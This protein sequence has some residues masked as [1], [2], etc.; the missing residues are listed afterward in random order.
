MKKKELLRLFSFLLALGIACSSVHVLPAQVYATETSSDDE[1]SEKEKE[2][3]AKEQAKKEMQEAVD[4]DKEK[5]DAAKLENSESRDALSNMAKEKANL[6]TAKD[7]LSEAVVVLDGQLADVQDQLDQLELLIARKQM[8]IMNLK[9]ELATAQ[10]T[11]AE[12][13][14]SMKKRIK[15]MYEKGQTSYVNVVFQAGSLVEMLNKAEYVEKVSAYDRKM[16]EEYQENAKTIE[17]LKMQLE[18]EEE[19]LENAQKDADDTSEEMSDLIVQKEDQIEKYEGQ[20]TNK[21][22]AIAEYEAMIAEQNA[23][24]AALEN[25]IREA[26]AEILAMDVSENDLGDGTQEKLT[27]GGGGF[28]WPAPSYTRISD[29]YGYRIHP[30]LGVKQFHNGVDMAAPGGSPILAAADGQVVAA[31]YSST[32]GN[33]VM[34]NHGSGVITIYMHASAVYVS[35]GSYVSAGQKIAAVGTT[36]RS[37]GNH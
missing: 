37:T 7:E 4:A 11:A 9:T 16:L 5:L 17:F 26:E 15:F 34:I 3:E 1:K 20:I 32:M 29:D 6:E 28:V 25:S 19:D 36:G 31:A 10:D 8:E 18:T 12:Q 27:Y 23:I 24:I 13:Y 35:K 30:T 21:E 2:K 14:D 22:A 33:Y